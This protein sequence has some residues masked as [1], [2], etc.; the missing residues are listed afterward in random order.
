MFLL[1]DGSTS[2]SGQL[3]TGWEGVGPVVGGAKV[4]AVALGSCDLVMVAVG[5]GGYGGGGG[6]GGSGWVEWLQV[7]V[8][9]SLNLQV[10]AGSG[11]SGSYVKEE[12][13]EVLLEAHSGGFTEG[14]DHWGGDG[15]SGGDGGAFRNGEVAGDGGNG[16][17]DGEDGIDSHMSPGGLGSGEE[18]LEGIPQKEFLLR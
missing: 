10:Q 4:T 12:G 1:E 9:G 8:E 11:N 14:Y 5:G 2:S 16:G 3:I 18:L 13:G 15:Y 6:G 17:G 7:S